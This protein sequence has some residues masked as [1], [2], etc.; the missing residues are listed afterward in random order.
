MTAPSYDA[1]AETA[2][3]IWPAP[4][5][6]GS[7]RHSSGGD[8]AVVREFLLAPSAARPRIALP[9]GAPQAAADVVRKYSQGLGTREYVSRTLL[10]RLLGA[11]PV[12][13]LVS[14]LLPDR[15]RIVAPAGACIDS[16]E[17]HLAELLGEDVLL[18]ISVGPSRANRKPVLQAVTPEGQTLAYVKVGISDLTRSLV[19]G[20]AAALSA[21]WS[22]GDEENT[23][24]A[25]H[26][27][28]HETWRDL[29]I[30]VLEAIRP[31]HAGILAH[32]KRRAEEPLAAMREFGER[33]GVTRDRLTGNRFWR[34]IAA[35]PDQ[36]LDSG[37]AT[38]Y[39]E[40]AKR[41]EACYSS[42]DVAFGCWHGDWTPWNM[43]WDA[44]RVLLWDF[45]RFS[46][47]VPRGFDLAHYRLQTRLLRGGED[48]AEQ[49]IALP[50]WTGAE[51]TNDPALV[52]AAYL[53][54]LARRWA[55]A[56]QV[57]EGEPLRRRTQWLFEQLDRVVCR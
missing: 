34:R 46:T 27:L 47:H 53:L 3:L 32:R 29:E 43:V 39:A 54:E 49:L 28:H 9:A 45:E 50:G 40:A 48:A 13:A 31:R 30:L 15:L 6:V 23:L 33:L 10:G 51:G 55:L 18:G 41:V 37:Q 11:R 20:E 26:V 17:Q 2:A 16:L 24:R 42:A 19:A 4:A 52:A 38:R 14:R 8:A 44:E 56:A 12:H 21:Y 35:T 25:P 1:L 22:A 57:P 36:L 7:A 5:T